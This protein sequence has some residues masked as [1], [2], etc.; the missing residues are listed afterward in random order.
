MVRVWQCGRSL[1]LLSF[2]LPFNLITCD[3]CFCLVAKFIYNGK[4][5]VYI[6]VVE[7]NY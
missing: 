2:L 4:G 1:L 7:N 5:A 3:L 6:F